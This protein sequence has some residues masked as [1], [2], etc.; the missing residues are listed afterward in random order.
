MIIAALSLGFFA[1]GRVADQRN[2]LT[3]LAWLLL[4]ASGMAALTLISYD[5]LLRAI[6]ESIEDSR[7][8]AVV[9]ALVLFAPTS[10]FIGMTSPYL[11]KLNVRSLELTGR[12]IAS[13]DMF[14]AIG[15]IVGTFVT[16]FILF[17]YIGAHEA[18]GLVSVLL[19]AISWLIAPRIYMTRRLF[20]SAVL[21]LNALT[22]VGTITGIVKIDTAS[23]HYEVVSGF[24]DNRPVTGLVT[25]P[26]GTQSAVFASGIDEP[27]F[28]YNRELARLTM[29]REPATVLILGG[30]AFT[31]P[32]YL[33]DQ[34]PD[35]SIDVVEIDP[36]L[37]AISQQY[38]GYTN[39][40][41]VSEIFTDARAYVNQT[42]KRY[43]VVVV[44]VYGDT[45]IPFTFM[46]KEYGQALA[47]VL[48]PDGVV[49]ANII[50]GMSGECRLAFGAVDAAY[51]SS[52]PYA[53]YSNES[54]RDES[55]ANHVVMY[56]K[57]AMT[58]DGLRPLPDFGTRV[59]S[60]NFAPSER[61][62]YS[63]RHTDS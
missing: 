6:V 26:T 10:F 39:P 4:I 16:G 43:D 14:N 57:Q 48:S 35:A 55:R 56:S 53:Q 12:S 23:A 59:Y 13:L 44:D 2:R 62:F 42:S 51:R 32:Q 45:S 28:W 34:L 3:D 25:G 36:E 21:L 61:L 1:G 58:T 63:C 33:S 54:G 5:G 41:N 7:V 20:V 8:Q 52:L 22:P 24:I 29:D 46:T 60:D 49:V 17:G 40:S 31:L 11:A 47:N 37:Q 50:G 19:L 18:I 27:V 9:A 30:G 38:F 15:G